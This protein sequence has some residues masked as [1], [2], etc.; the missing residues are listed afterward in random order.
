MLNFLLLLLFIYVGS[1]FITNS[2]HD[3]DNDSGSCYKVYRNITHIC[4][5]ELDFYGKKYKTRSINDLRIMSG[6]I[7]RG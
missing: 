3:C 7:C 2:T 1:V 4:Y 6:M 5:L